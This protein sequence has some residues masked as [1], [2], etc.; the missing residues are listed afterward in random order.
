[1]PGSHAMVTVNAFGKR[2]PPV[3]DWE[4]R[5]DAGGCS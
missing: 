5:H 4:G 2:D 3:S 1:M